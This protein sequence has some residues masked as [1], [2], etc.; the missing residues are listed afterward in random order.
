[1][2]LLKQNLILALFGIL[3][4][5]LSSCCPATQATKD[6]TLAQKCQE[7]P[8]CKAALDKLSSDVK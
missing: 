8:S 4:L 1:M 6:M 7:T 2:K 3:M 5:T